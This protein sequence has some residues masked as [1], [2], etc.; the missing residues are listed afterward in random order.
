MSCR[1]ILIIE[2]DEDIL[3]MLKISLEMEGYQVSIAKNGREGLEILPQMPKPCLILL[4]LMMPVMD[5]WAFAEALGKDTVLAAIPVVVVTAFAEKVGSPTQ[6][7]AVIKKPIDLD[8]LFRI[9]GK[10]CGPAIH[11]DKS[12]NESRK[13]SSL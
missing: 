1:S 12:I 8:L 2:D 5:G 11:K 10:Y 13:N 4:D 9:V 3:D 7:S 6:A